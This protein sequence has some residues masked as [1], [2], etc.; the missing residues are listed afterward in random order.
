M[1][2]ILSADPVRVRAEM[3]QDKAERAKRR[4]LR[5]RIDKL[6]K[7]SPA[8]VAR[9]AEDNPA[10]QVFNEVNQKAARRKVN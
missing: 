3:E 2:A 9:D 4:R 1:D 5:A 10:L 8:R 7:E 6:N